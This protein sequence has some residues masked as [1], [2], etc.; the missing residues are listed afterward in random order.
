MKRIII[1]A[2]VVFAAACASGEP[3]T[4]ANPSAVLEPADAVIVSGVQA[5]W[6][7]MLI[8][9]ADDAF[10][11][12]VA[13]ADEAKRV[14]DRAHNWNVDSIPSFKDKAYAVREYS[15]AVNQAK[16]MSS[17]AGIAES[18][19]QAIEAEWPLELGA[20]PEWSTWLSAAYNWRQA[21]LD[22]SAAAP[23]FQIFGSLDTS[24]C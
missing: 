7:A 1:T 13:D 9:D 3:L 2:V 12:A 19:A 8:K 10:F 16:L 4:Q 18:N 21:A 6:D 14:N 20:I 15:L 5:A 22:Y 23:W 11:D 17:F 24:E